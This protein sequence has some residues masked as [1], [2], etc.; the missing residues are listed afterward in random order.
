MKQLQR[1]VAGLFNVTAEEEKQL[2]KK[3]TTHT[4]SAMLLKLFKRRL[5][6]SW[7]E[8]PSIVGADEEPDVV[9]GDPM[10][11][12]QPPA[13]QA[14]KLDDDSAAEQDELISMD[15]TSSSEEEK[16]GP[17]DV[18]Q[19]SSTLTKCFSNVSQPKRMRNVCPQRSN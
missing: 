4:V 17:S 1:L 3:R 11:E 19:Y 16:A 10:A 13:E 8:V 2:R 18:N 12:V 15:D 14:A 7:R 5:T 6:G 9:A